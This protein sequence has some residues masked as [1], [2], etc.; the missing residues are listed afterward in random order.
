MARGEMV[1]WLSENQIEEPEKIKEFHGLDYRYREEYSSDTEFVFLEKSR[2]RRK[3][4]EKGR[5][6][7]RDH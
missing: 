2:I 3:S 7:K 1:R 5:G 6:S 4:G